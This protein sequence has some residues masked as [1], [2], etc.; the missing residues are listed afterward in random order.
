M[1]LDLVTES[2]LYNLKTGKA[3]G[4]AAYTHT[5]FSCFSEQQI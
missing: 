4:K 5:I 3:E 2:G 1:F